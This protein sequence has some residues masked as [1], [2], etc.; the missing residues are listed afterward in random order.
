M[1]A[2]KRDNLSLGPGWGYFVEPTRYKE[3]LHK[4]VAE[5]DVS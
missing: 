5:I 4:Y 2:N 1:R 3:H